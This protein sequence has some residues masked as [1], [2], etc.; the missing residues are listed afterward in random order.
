[1]QTKLTLRLDE[2]VIRRAKSYA[3]KQKTNLSRMI[4]DYFD[5]LQNEAS[6]EEPITPLVREL[7]GVLPQS[8][9]ASKLIK[10]RHE[11]FIKK[12]K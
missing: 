6:T 4:S 10:A 7:T 1:M 9:D 12:H 2:S 5:S 3:K 8:I 11:T